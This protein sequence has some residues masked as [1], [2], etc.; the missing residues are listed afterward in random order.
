MNVIIHYF[1]SAEDA[2]DLCDSLNQ[3]RPGT[4][5]TL[6]ADLS[7][8]NQWKSLILQAVDIFQRL[9]ILVNNASAF[10]ATPMGQATDGDWEQLLDINLKAP[11]F[12]SEYAAPHLRKVQGTIINIVDIHADRPMKSYP[13]YSISK[14]GLKMLTKTLARE[15]GPDIRVNAVSPGPIMWPEGINTYSD[16]QKLQIIDATTLKQHGDPKEIAKA[17]LFLAKDANYVSGLDL[18]VDGGRSVVI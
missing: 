10:F 12:L 2:L 3:I 6:K 8:K 18:I 17:V 13:I 11:F 7:D 15:L 4:A 1:H 9:D 16:A 14:A 5:A